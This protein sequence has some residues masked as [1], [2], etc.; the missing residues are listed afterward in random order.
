MARNRA[1]DQE[2]DG[3]PGRLAQHPLRRRQRAGCPAARDEAGRDDRQDARDMEHLL[4]RRIDAERDQQREDDREDRVVDARDQL[5]GEPAERE[6]DQDAADR[7]DHEPGRRIEQRE[8]PAG[9]GR[10]GRAQRDQRRRIVHE[11]LALED[12]DHPARHPEPLEDGR[13]GDGVR[14]RDDRAERERGRPAQIRHQQMRHDRDRGHREQDEA[15][16]QQEDGPQV[17]LELADRGEVARTEQDRWQEQQEDEVGLEVDI[18]ERRDEAQDQP[19]DDQHDGVRD[20]QLRASPASTVAAS[21]STKMSATGSMIRGPRG[22]SGGPRATR[23]PP[24]RDRRPKP[25][26]GAAARPRAEAE[27][28]AEEA[29]L[30]RERAGDRVG[31][32]EAV[33]LA[34]ERAGTRA[35]RRRSNSAST[36]RSA[37]ARGTILSSAPCRTS[38]GDVICSAWRLGERSR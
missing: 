28:L 36:I 14:R 17:G 25:A 20:A 11:A 1:V 24:P 31:A 12:G 30:R 19:A 16:G 32:A 22:A 37:S 8:R 23:H 33:I 18:R 27:D 3:A 38:T 15:D 6:A 35:G 10:Q 7:D 21:R 5:P 29:Q 34:R 13:R 26:P 9:G 4:G 2:Q